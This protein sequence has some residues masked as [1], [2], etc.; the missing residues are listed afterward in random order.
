MAV[1]QN[2]TF[3]VNGYD[4]AP[5]LQYFTTE[6]T[7]E[8]IDATVLANN[9]RS[10][11]AGFHSATIEGEGKF[12]TDA[13]D[14]DTMYDTQKTAF[15]SAAEQ[16]V[17]ASFGIVATG[18]VALMMNAINTKF[19]VVVPKGLLILNNIMLAS[20][21]ALNIG[22]WLTKAQR[23]AGTFTGTAVD[24]AT[25]ST[26]G[27]LSHVHLE[28]DTATGVTVLTQH[29][30]NNSAW[31]DL[32]EAVF[33]TRAMGSYTFGANPSDT[34]TIIF[35]G[36][37]F[38]FITGSSTATDIQIKGTLAL[39][40]VEAATVLNASVNGSVSVATYTSTATKINVSYD[41]PG[42]GG[43]AYTL[44]TPTAGNVTRSGATLSGGVDLVADVHSKYSET[45][46]AGTTVRRYLRTITKV[47][48]GNT[49]LV[50]SAFAR[51]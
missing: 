40:L 3:L 33:G 18:D 4:L 11:E 42:T 20:N 31:V 9:Y 12:A 38:T 28:N 29:S 44:D 48:G 27:G 10:K 47:Y 24:N 34:D 22:R 13:V 16:V 2:I 15:S 35:N 50:S 19:D 6:G 37:T 39:T 32:S 46:A 30:T 1:G 21:N 41:A 26:N 7:A 43:N 36:V 17:T 45:I 8:S 14:A 5:Y 23:N 51:R 25:Q 49:V